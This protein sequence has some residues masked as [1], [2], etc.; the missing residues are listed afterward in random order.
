MGA[1]MLAAG[2][3]GVMGTQPPEA[4]VAAAGAR[5]PEPAADAA[6]TAA[7]LGFGAAAGLLYG[8]L[9]PRASSPGRDAAAGIGY[10]LAVYAGSYAGWVPALG[11][12]PPPHRDRPGRQVTTALAHVLYGAVLGLGTGRLATARWAR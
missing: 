11:I 10:G 6:A 12:L 9:R 8:A 7:H 5:R 3:A 2:R 1:L 4:I